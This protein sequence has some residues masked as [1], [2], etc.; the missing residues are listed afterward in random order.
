MSDIRWGIWVWEH[1]HL[2]ICKDTANKSCESQRII[3]MWLIQSGFQFLGDVFGPKN[4]QDT[5]SDPRNQS[6]RS[7]QPK[8]KIKT[9]KLLPALLQLY[10][11]TA[12]LQLLHKKS[13]R[14][15]TQTWTNPTS[16]LLSTPPILP[17]FP[18][19]LHSLLVFSLSI[20]PF[21]LWLKRLKCGTL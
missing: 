11:E 2:Q 5:E 7:P 14:P 19:L 13:C 15:A 20:W 3:I 6:K 10:Y 8:N 21:K 9:L 18:M 1:V 17:S 4:T 12:T 16:F